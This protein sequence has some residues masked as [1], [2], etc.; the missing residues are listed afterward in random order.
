M[1]QVPHASPRPQTIGQV[2]DNAFRIFQLSLAKCLGISI[3]SMLAGQLA[4]LYYLAAGK[5]LQSFNARDPL[6]WALYGV[7]ALLSLALWSA[8]MLRQRK[9][10]RQQPTSLPAELGEALRRV[11]ALFLASLVIGILIAMG[12]VLLVVPGIYLITALSLTWPAL[13]FAGRGPFAAMLYSVDLVRNNWWRTTAVFAVTMIIALVFYFAMFATLGIT[14]QLAGSNDV[15]M[16]TAA[17]VVV[18]IVLGALGAPFYSAVLL[19]LFE[20][21]N[22]RRLQGVASQG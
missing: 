7:G 20:D 2:L 12:L 6:W 8:L 13:L 11:P 16:F 19:A 1:P 21:L 3:L 17:A 9:V 14:M 5:P 4:S 22:R 15:A 18:V 10:V